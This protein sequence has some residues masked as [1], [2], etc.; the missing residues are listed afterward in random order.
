MRIERANLRS[1]QSGER[2]IRSQAIENRESSTL[3]PFKPS[4][5]TLEWIAESRSLVRKYGHMDGK[6]FS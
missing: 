4:A 3:E 2:A 6:D 1:T 5:R